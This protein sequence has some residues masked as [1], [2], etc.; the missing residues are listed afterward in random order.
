MN[1]YILAATLIATV[2]VILLLGLIYLYAL[3]L[4]K[5]RA[6]YTTGLLIFS[7]MLLVQNAVTVYGY[8]ELSN[9][10]A[11]GF[12]PYLVGVAICECVGLLALL[13]VTV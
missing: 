4:L 1:Q 6:S 12:Y 5:T 9:F 2:N 8:A 7:I 11:A 10:I 13:R 3:I